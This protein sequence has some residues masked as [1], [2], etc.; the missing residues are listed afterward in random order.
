[1]KAGRQDDPGWWFM[2]RAKWVGSSVLGKELRRSA[3][4]RSKRLKDAPWVF[5]LSSQ[6]VILPFMEK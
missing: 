6:R 1:M 4:K 3:D 2:E 5:G